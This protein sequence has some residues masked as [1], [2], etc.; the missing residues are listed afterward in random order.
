MERINSELKKSE[1]S[2][3]HGLKGG[4][5]SKVAYYHKVVELHKK[6]KDLKNEMNTIKSIVN[7]N[8]P[9]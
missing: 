3:L 4:Q 5:M 9:I 6:V 2:L 7:S 8:S 1:E